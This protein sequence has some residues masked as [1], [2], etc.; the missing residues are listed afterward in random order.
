MAPLSFTTALWV[1][2][3][4]TQQ[5]KL[6]NMNFLDMLSGVSELASE[7]MSAAEQASEASSAE[8]ANKWPSPLRVDFI[9]VLPTVHGRR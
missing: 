2:T 8:Q 1:V 6:T 5:I 7:R 4:L 3:V 9:A